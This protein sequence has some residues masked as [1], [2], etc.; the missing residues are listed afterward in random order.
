MSGNSRQEAVATIS[1]SIAMT[2]VLDTSC[3]L[4]RVR[5]TLSEIQVESSNAFSN[6]LARAG[7]SVASATLKTKSCGSW[8]VSGR[9]SRFARRIKSWFSNTFPFALK[10]KINR[11]TKIWPDESSSGHIDSR[12]RFAARLRIKLKVFLT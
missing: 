9:L 2:N 6:R 8:G 7:S 10:M 5:L 1:F 4:V 12:G 3:A 11:Q